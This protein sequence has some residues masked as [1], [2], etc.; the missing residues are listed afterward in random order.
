MPTG[1]PGTSPISDSPGGLAGNVPEGDPRLAHLPK[2]T[3][4]ASGQ[5]SYAIQPGDYAAS[6]IA[7]KFKRAAQWKALLSVNPGFAWTQGKVGDVI[8]VPNEWGVK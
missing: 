5:L 8:N 2:G 4:V 1:L 3:S 7:K 6:V